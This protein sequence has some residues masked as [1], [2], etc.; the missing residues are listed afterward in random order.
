[1]TTL[2]VQTN[3]NKSRESICVEKTKPGLLI[4]FEGIDGTGK[5][6][7]AK[8][9]KFK[10]EGLGLQVELFKEPT[11]QTIEGQKLRASYSSGRVSLEQELDWFMRDRAW[12]VRERVLPAL[13]RGA[14]VLLDRYFFSTA[15]YQG[16]R[17][18]ND[19]KSILALNRREFPEPDLTIIF[20]LEPAIALQRIYSQRKKSNTFEGL[21]YLSQVRALFLEIYHTDNIGK[22]LLLNAN[23]GIYELASELFKAVLPLLEKRGMV[24]TNQQ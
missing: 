6:T 4:V 16:A 14:I 8:L 23:K 10:L 12:N 22:Y 24:G 7:Q 19:W 2:N 18:N 15:C 21:E 3:Y 17:K 1:M 9:L 11:D 5:T 13:K 20:D